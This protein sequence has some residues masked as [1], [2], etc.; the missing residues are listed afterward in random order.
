MDA[1]VTTVR[2]IT[3][4]IVALGGEG[5]GVLADWIV[6]VAQHGGYIAQAT[7]VPGVAQRTGATVY[8][9]ELFP[10]AAAQAAGREPV[11]GLLPMPG[12]VDVVLASELMEAARAV[13]R[14]FVTPDKTLLIASTHRVFAMTEKIALADGRVD[15]AALLSACRTAARQLVAFDMAALADATGSVVSAVLFG[16]LAGSG[17]L[18]MQRTAFEAAVRRGQVGVNSSLAAFAAAFEAAQSGET[19][20]PA[21]PPESVATGANSAPGRELALSDYGGEA[22]A[23][24]AAALDRVVDYQDGDYGSDLLRR[25]SRFREIERQHGDGSGRLV[26]EVARQ[27]ALAMSYEDTVRVAELK[28]RPSRFVRVREEA[29][30]APGQILEISEFFHPRVQEIADTLPVT[31][32][33]W[34]LRTTWARRLIERLLR[35]GKIVKTTSLGGFLLLY[36]LSRLKPLRRRS[37]RFAREQESITEWLDRVAETAPTDYAL[38]LELARMR[39]LVK[40]YGETLERGRAN[41]DKLTA[42]L[43]RLRARADAGGTL[44]GLIKAALADEEG[45]ALEKAVTELNMEKNAMPYDLDQFVSDCRS[46]LKRDPGPAGREEVRTRLERLLSNKEFVEEYCGEHVPRGLKLL[47]EDPELGFQVLAHINDKARV[48]PPHDHG[49]S[50]AI[51]GQATKYTEMTEWERKDDGS[52]PGKAKLNPVKK[53]RLLPGHAGIYQDGTIHSIDYPDQARFVRV[54]GTNLDRI[55]RVSFDL[56]SGKVNQMAPQQAT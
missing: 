50:W 3:I 38:A 36:A 20:H 40:G 39:G 34:L 32:G 5:G 12:D 14:G 4:A 9:V 30:L 46:V 15:S 55:P 18:P 21:V 49:A 54:T 41:F 31:A 22:R 17:A 43:P 47:Y 19:T 8:Y 37:L 44:A 53:Y 26:I 48:S 45:R 16:A 11:L 33:D 35:K 27:L 1:Q 51:Y 2:P 10:K 23:V 56:A 7:S 52:D 25:L 13:E 29:Q 42:L 24:V 28:I 6:D